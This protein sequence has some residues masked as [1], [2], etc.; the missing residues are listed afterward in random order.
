MLIQIQISKGWCTYIHLKTKLMA[1]INSIANIIRNFW[2]SDSLC[3]P[4][5]ATFSVSKTD[6]WD[7]IASDWKKKKRKTS[8]NKHTNADLVLRQRIPENRWDLHWLVVYQAVIIFP[9]VWNNGTMTC[10]SCIITLKKTLN[11]C[12]KSFELDSCLNFYLLSQ[13]EFLQH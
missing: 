13:A 7:K 5:N 9:V 4:G 12:K 11:H 1:G 3:D 6:P 10:R 8:V 2:I